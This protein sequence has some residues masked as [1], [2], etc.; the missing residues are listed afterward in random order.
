MNG[1]E[2]VGDSPSEGDDQA[3]GGDK[4]VKGGGGDMLA[5]G[6][7]QGGEGDMLAEGGGG[8]HQAEG[9]KKTCKEE[10]GMS[11]LKKRKVMK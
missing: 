10:K 8:A 1:D 4:L 11:Q 5:E 9:G 3:R 2:A 6:G 7:T